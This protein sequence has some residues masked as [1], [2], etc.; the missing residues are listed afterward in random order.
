MC[1]DN[2]RMSSKTTLNSSGLP[3]PEN[4]IARPVTTAN[5]LAVRGEPNLARITCDRVP[6][7][8]FFAILPKIVRGVD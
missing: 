6:C 1:N 4:D 8:S 5:P 3:V 7:K 2:F